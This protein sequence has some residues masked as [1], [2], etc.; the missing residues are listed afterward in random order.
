MKPQFTRASDAVSQPAA[1][2]NT[3]DSASSEP[4]DGGP[5][6]K[7]DRFALDPKGAPPPS[8]PAEG[9]REAPNPRKD[10]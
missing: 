2:T 5:G 6:P 8:H 7:S 4:S 9:L 10:G 1:P 3:T